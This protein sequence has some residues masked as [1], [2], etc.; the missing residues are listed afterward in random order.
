MSRKAERTR[1]RPRKGSEL[2]ADKLLDVALLA[3]AEHGFDK[4]NLRLIAAAAK[5]DVA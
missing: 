3:F 5:V 2:D 1:G 4:A